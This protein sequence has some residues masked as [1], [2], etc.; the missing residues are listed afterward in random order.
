VVC[1]LEFFTPL[2]WG[3]NFVKS[4]TFLK[5]FNALDAPIRGVQVLMGHQKQRSPR[6]KFGLPWAIKCLLTNC[7]TL[8]SK[9]SHTWTVIWYNYKITYVIIERLC[10]V[11][12]LLLGFHNNLVIVSIMCIDSHMMIH[13]K[14][15]VRS[16]CHFIMHV[17]SHGEPWG[18]VWCVDFKKNSCL[19]SFWIICKRVFVTFTFTW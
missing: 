14:S 13:V 4:Y 3:H 1:F 9:V 2:I 19:S 18:V 8:V 16:F 10:L 11:I 17:K 15:Q 12:Y 6:F 5:I 7:S